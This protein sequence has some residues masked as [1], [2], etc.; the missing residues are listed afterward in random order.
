MT[1]RAAF[2]PAYG[3]GVSDTATSPSTSF[4]VDSA[5]KRSGGGSKAVCVT[6]TGSIAMYVKVGTGTITASAADHIILPGT[7]EVLAKAE[8]DD[9]IAVFTA[10][11]STTFHAIAGEGQ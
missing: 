5:T 3:T 6:N 7:K 1:I 8:T 9:K 2:Q 4:T 10:T 11:S